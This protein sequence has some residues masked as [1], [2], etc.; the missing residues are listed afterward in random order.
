[1]ENT[2]KPWEE[3]NDVEKQNYLNFHTTSYK[4]DIAHAE[5]V[6]LKFPRWSIISGY[7][8]MHDV[9]KLFLARRFKIKIVSPQIHAKT[10]AAIDYFIKDDELR[11]KIIP[12]LKEAQQTFYN[13]ERL[14]EKVIPLLLKQSKKQREQSQYYNEDYSEKKSINAQKA[15]AF[16]EQMVKPYIKIIEGLL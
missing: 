7:Y 3:L 4:E 14:K 11:Q 13:V 2:E 15:M 6:V 5:F 10:I 9:T 8:A 12:L 16:L 1:M